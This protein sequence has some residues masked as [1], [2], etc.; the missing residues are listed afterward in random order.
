MHSFNEAGRQGPAP[1]R[2]R[3]ARRARGIGSGAGPVYCAL[4]DAVVTLMPFIIFKPRFRFALPAREA[5]SSPTG[6]QHRTLIRNS[7]SIK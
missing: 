6:F 3:Q 5:D 2:E 1:T 7:K 4:V